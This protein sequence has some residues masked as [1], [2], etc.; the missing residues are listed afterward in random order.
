MPMTPASGSMRAG[1]R[2]VTATGMHSVTQN[3]AIRSSTYK[4]HQRCQNNDN[5]SADLSPTYKA[6][7]CVLRNTRRMFY[8]E[9]ALLVHLKFFILLHINLLTCS[10][11]MSG[12]GRRRIGIKQATRNLQS[13]TSAR[14]T[15]LME[16]R[17]GGDSGEDASSSSSA[18]AVT[19][20]VADTGRSRCKLVVFAVGR[21]LP[22]WGSMECAAV[23]VVGCAVELILEI[24]GESVSWTLEIENELYLIRF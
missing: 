8:C 5:L 4:H 2:P 18:S 11:R 10:R 24:Q 21:W 20:E 23:Y 6:N 14:P 9:N 7:V 1:S 19:R 22:M 13:R 15:H 16:Q 12:I 17:S 3:I